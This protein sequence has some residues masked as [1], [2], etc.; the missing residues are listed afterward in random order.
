MKMY[1]DKSTA[2][3]KENSDGT[4]SIQNVRFKIELNPFFISELKIFP[5]GV[6]TPPRPAMRK[7]THPC[8]SDGKCAPLF[9]C[10]FST[11]SA[12]FRK[13]FQANIMLLFVER[14]DFGGCSLPI[15]VQ[16][17]EARL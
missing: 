4:I 13:F 8:L 1:A 5:D 2:V 15:L 17:V 7:G 6:Q 14:I 3:R 12:E 16:A 10:R 9:D 11:K